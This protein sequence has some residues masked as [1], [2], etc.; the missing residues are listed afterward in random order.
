MRSGSVSFLTYNYKVTINSLFRALSVGAVAV[1]AVAITPLSASALS[2]VEYVIVE[3]DGSVA[4]RS[5]TQAQAVKASIDPSVRIVQP[6]NSFQIE[7]NTV[8]IVTGLSVPTNAQVGD[9]VPGRYIV[10]LSS[11]TASAVAVASLTSG[12]ITTFSNAISGFVA[13]LTDSEVAALQSNPNVVSVEADRIVSISTDQ[14]QPGWGLDRIDQRALPLNQNYSYTTTGVGV[15]AYVVDSGINSTH[16]EFT[17]RIK[18][19]FTVIADGRGVEDCNGHGTHVSGIM[20]GTKYGVAKS[21][22][23]VPVRVLGCNGSG[24]VSGLISG[25]NWAI[26]NHQ[27]GVPAVANLS[28]GAG[29]SSSLNNAVA[30]T[31]ADG[32]TVVVA[33]GN[34]NANACSYSPAS[35]PSAIT[36]GATVPLNDSRAYFSNYGTCVDIFAPGT[37][38]PSAYVGSPIAAASMSGTSMASPFVAGIAAVYLEDHTSATPTAVTTAIT[39]ASTRDVI[40]NVGLGSPNKLVFSASFEPAPTPTPTTTTTPTP[41]PTTTTAPT[42][43]PS[44]PLALTATPS[45]QTVALAWSLPTFDGRSAITDYKIEYTSS[46][47]TA[48]TVFAHT[49]STTRTAKITG[50][51]NGTQYSF[52]VSAVNSVG[53]GVATSPI[54]ST[55][56]APATLTAP[57]NLSGTVGRQ[58][59]ILSWQQPLVL[60]GASITDYIIESSVDNGVTWVT[61]NDGVSATRTSTISGLSGNIAYTFRVKAVNATG[62][63]PASNTVVLTPLPLDPPTVPR[64]LAVYA[65]F[66][67]ATLYWATP[68]SDGGSRITGYRTEYSTDGGTTWTGSDIASETNRSKVYANLVGGVLHKFRVYAINAVGTS[69]ASAVVESTPIAATVSSQPRYLNGFLSGTSAYLSWTRPLMTGGSAITSYTTW[70]STNAGATWTIIAVTGANVRNA[71]VNNLAYGVQYEFRVT[72]ANAAG[73]SAPS[74]TFTLQLRGTGTPNPPSSIRATVNTTSITLAWSA[75]VATAAPVTDYIIEYRTDT[76]AAWST[77]NDGVSTA[78][79]ATLTNMTPDVP[80]SLR[81][82]AVNRYGASPASAMVTVTPRPVASAPSAP[83]SV[84][85]TAGDTRVAVRWVTP[86]NSG[87]SAISSYTVMSTPGGFTCTTS[88]NACVVVGLTNGESYTF[89]VTARNASGISV[90]SEPSAPVSPVASGSVTAPAASWG[91]DRTDQRSLPLDGKITRSGTGAGVSAYIIDTGVYSASAEFTGRVA[92]GFTAFNDGNG[93]NDCHSH[94]THVAG[95]VAG[96]TYGFATEATVIPVRVLDCNGSGSTAGIVA[97][98]DWIIQHHKAGTPAVANMSLGSMSGVDLAINDAVAR[99]V[100]DGITFVVAAG[101]FYSNACNYSPSSEA[102]A[103]T[104]GAITFNDAF[105]DFSNRGSCVDILAPGVQI[106]SAAITSPTATSSKSGTSMAAPHVAG[107]VANMLGN[108]PTL[109]PAQVATQL[110]ATA[111]KTTLTGLPT[112]TTN[113]LLYQQ[114]ASANSFSLSVEVDISET[115]TD[116]T[117]DDSSVVEYEVDPG[118]P[119]PPVVTIPPKTNDGVS[120]TPP[121]VPTTRPVGSTN[122]APIEVVAPPAVPQGTSAMTKVSISKITKVGK[123]LRVTVSAP[124]GSNVSLYRNGKLVG[125]GM[126]KVFLVPVSVAKKQSFTAVISVAGAFV[127]S[128]TVLL[129]VR[130]ASQR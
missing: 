21:A 120:T 30:S 98:I 48:W 9:V 16:T 58:S 34:S 76:S 14:S 100:A 109:T 122:G 129:P 103:I 85:A 7:D 12:A 44:V 102:L 110:V 54:F 126:K 15:T 106:I 46:N 18:S 22:S 20:A 96:S 4:V 105:A 66:N 112:G 80:V 32:I 61:V 114:P 41:A 55:P 111:T 37:S 39:N 53:T 78:V 113:T 81:V 49:A 13:D 52:R 99:G 65:S 130:S 119:Q 127:S 28:V 104:V 128:P 3:R 87:G 51:T 123:Q 10:Q 43:V 25:L 83:L 70:M 82:K 72:A 29:A 50:L 59:V 115:I 31:V 26:N 86:V 45:S 64:S 71:R 19:G 27:A 89:T 68:L 36:V 40:T 97:G 69:Q 47:S 79:T 73:N 117:A 2:T 75:V 5:L 108:A 63:S 11:N 17:G 57:L 77:W 84:T 38:I 35:A 8:D 74:A 125:K 42:T 94:G 62:T 95:T 56:V 24:S 91:L 88:T 118:V 90:A 23:I 101:N 107:V 33:A 93:T 92:S 124:K 60:A 116:I 67:G 121:A 6:N 1:S